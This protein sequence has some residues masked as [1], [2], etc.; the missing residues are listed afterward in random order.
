MQ[1]TSIQAWKANYQ[2]HFIPEKSVGMNV[3]VQ[4]TLHGGEPGDWYAI[5]CDQ[6]A[7]LF[8][9]RVENPNVTISTDSSVMLDIFNG[10]LNGSMAFLQ[11]KLKVSGDI[12]LSIRLLSVF[13]P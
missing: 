3:T 13:R 1:E 6:S 7:Q 8:D 2:A 10:K 9:G 12:P 5:I 4:F 11:A